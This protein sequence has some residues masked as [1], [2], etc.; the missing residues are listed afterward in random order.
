MRDLFVIAFA[1]D[2]P[3]FS[4]ITNEIIDIF[5]EINKIDPK[6][7]EDVLYIAPEQIED[8]YPTEYEEKTTYLHRLLYLW[9]R[10]G[11]RSKNESLQYIKEVSKKMNISDEDFVMEYDI[12]NDSDLSM[13]DK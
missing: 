11:N 3:K 6:K 9:K 4:P 13:W 12:V 1:N 2:G 5:I 10:S 8:I 7:K